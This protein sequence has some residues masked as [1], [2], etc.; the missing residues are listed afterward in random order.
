M[1]SLNN[2]DRRIPTNVW[3]LKPVLRAAH[4]LC[5][6]PSLVRTPE[7]SLLRL[8]HKCVLS[9][10]LPTTRLQSYLLLVIEIRCNTSVA[11]ITSHHTN[12]VDPHQIR[13][14]TALSNPFYSSKKSSSFSGVNAHKRSSIQFWFIPKCT[15]I[16]MEPIESE[17]IRAAVLL[18]S[19]SIVLL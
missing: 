12:D 14:V 1:P 13:G 4:F 3:E 7:Y 19:F 6:G 5:C 17:T 11:P 10:Y 18:F 9:L 15:V 16:P 2:R 8:S